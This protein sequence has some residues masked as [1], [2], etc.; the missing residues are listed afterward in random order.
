MNALVRRNRHEAVEEVRVGPR[1]EDSVESDTEEE[2]AAPLRIRIR[3]RI[4]GDRAN[5]WNA[6]CSLTTYSHSTNPERWTSGRPNSGSNR[7]WHVVK[8]G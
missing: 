1:H 7:S 2:D 4:P 8:H 5:T 3:I 6:R